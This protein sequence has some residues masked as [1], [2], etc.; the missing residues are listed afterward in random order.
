M[1]QN[2]IPRVQRNYQK[3][4]FAKLFLFA[5]SEIDRNF[6]GILSKFFRKVCQIFI[7][8][9]QKNNLTKWEFQLKKSFCSVLS[10]ERK[11]MDFLAKFFQHTS[12]KCILLV[13][14]K[15]LREKNLFNKKREKD[16]TERW[17]KFFPTTKIYCGWPFDVS[18][19]FCI[20]KFIRHGYIKTFRR[21]FV[22]SE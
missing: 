15:I 20:Q 19:C 1:S 18:E 16:N 10:I 8:C 6:S 3:M 9:V 17:R 13:Q 2:Y 21:M 5:I 7:F 22:V 14:K 4:L 12:Q 11:D